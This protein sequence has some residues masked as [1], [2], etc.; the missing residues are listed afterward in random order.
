MYVVS[1][2]KHVTGEPLVQ[3]KDDNAET[4]KNRLKAFHAQT[5]PVSWNEKLACCYAACCAAVFPVV[6]VVCVGLTVELQAAQGV[7]CTD[8]ACEWVGAVLRLCYV[9]CF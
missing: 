9:L 7:P 5:K 8:Q 2:G 3:R 6:S 4:L 1:L